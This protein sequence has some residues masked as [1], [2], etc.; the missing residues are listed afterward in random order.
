MH[1][2]AE[3][4]SR[5]VIGRAAKVHRALRPGLPV[6]AYLVLDPSRAAA[7]ARSRRESRGRVQTHGS[8]T[9]ETLY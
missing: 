3:P 1:M 6:P 5:Q 7:I 2:D 9:L 4:F 8:R